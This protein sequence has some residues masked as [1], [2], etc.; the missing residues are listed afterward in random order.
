MRQRELGDRLA[1]DGEQR[2]S[3]LELERRLPRALAGA[4]RLR[5]ADGE[6]AEPLQLALRGRDARREDELQ[7]AE[8][9]LT[10][11]ER[12]N[13]ALPVRQRLEA[14]R[15]P[16][17]RHETCLRRSRGLCLLGSRRREEL[18]RAV[19][20]RRPDQ[21]RLGARSP[22][23]NPDHVLRAPGLVE[24]GR[25][26]VARERQRGF[27]R[28]RARA[29]SVSGAERPEDEPDL[30]GG[31]L[32]AGDL[33]GFEPPCG[34]QQLD[35]PERSPSSRRPEAEARRRRRSGAPLGAQLPGGRP[36]KTLRQEARATE[37]LEPASSAASA[38]ER[39]ITL[40][41]PSIRPRRPP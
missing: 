30:G 20:V 37:K 31:E 23:G 8:R 12:R 39:L 24:P 7:D 19:L 1:D 35:A 15:F 34:A 10:E 28:D 17:L 41:T 33:A 3:M 18:E 21:R 26:G 4:K 16:L 2:L 5:R 6:C 25:E 27:G 32:R 29:G 36:A 9:R 13:R 14:D 11:T 38:S 40:R 22:C